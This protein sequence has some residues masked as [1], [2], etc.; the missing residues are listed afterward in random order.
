MTLTRTYAFLDLGFISHPTLNEMF[1]ISEKCTKFYKKLCLNFKNF[2]TL[3][4]ELIV[5]DSSWKEIEIRKTFKY[6]GTVQSMEIVT[7]GEPPI[8][9]LMLMNSRRGP[10]ILGWTPI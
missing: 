8:F 3:T 6:L 10:P 7:R 5:E 4:C 1:E 2:L 9:R